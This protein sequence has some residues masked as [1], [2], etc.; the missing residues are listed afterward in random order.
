MHTL[1]LINYANLGEAL[2][3]TAIF[4]IVGILLMV[5][6][7][8]VFDWITP[9]IDVQKELAERNNIAVGIVIAAVFIG[10]AIIISAAMS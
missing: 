7:Y 4:G 3:A 6:G 1:A 9:R 10:V 8:K 5:L 2:L